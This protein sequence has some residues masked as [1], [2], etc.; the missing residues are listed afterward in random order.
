[1]RVYQGSKKIHKWVSIIIAIPLFIIFV[2]GVL[3]SIAP[4]VNWLQP[5]ASKPVAPELKLN[6]EDVL[7]IA[8][9]I[10]EAEVSNW[11]D[12]TQL[13]VRPTLGVIRVRAKNYWEIQI[14]AATG[15][16]LS[17]GLRIK[18]LLVAIHE[19]AW[20]SDAV[21]YYI[22]FPAAIGALGLLLSG[23]VLFFTPVFKRRK[24]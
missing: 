16:I 13:D 14:D 20:F 9:T 17:S 11:K 4:K 8:K 22:F 1:M 3:L 18:T 19:G 2:S 23:L 7:K 5:S 15:E 12:I 24:V 21:R 10:P 6:Y